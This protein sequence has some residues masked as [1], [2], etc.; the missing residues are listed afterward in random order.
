MARWRTVVVLA[1]PALLLAAF[2]LAIPSV[3]TALP[4]MTQRTVY[5]NPVIRWDFA[6]PHVMKASDGFYYAYSTEHLT[7]ER[8]AYIQV[9]RSKDL[10][11]WELLPDA[12]PEKPEWADTTRDFWAPG[13]IEADGRYYMYFSGIHDERESMCLGVATSG[14]PG[15]PFVP[16]EDPLRCGDGFVNIDPM[17]FDDPQTGKSLL[18]WGSDGAPI[19]VQQLA[20]D[21]LG[22]APG[23]RAKDL[24]FTDIIQPYERLVEGAF[25]VYRDDYYYLFYSGDNCCLPAPSY[26]VMVARSPSATG[27]FEKRS[28]TTGVWGSNVILQQNDRW[29]GTGHNSVVR[30]EAGRDWIFYHAIDPDDRYNPGTE[31]S[32]RPMLMDPIVYRSGWP[33]I[34]ESSPSTTKR[35]GPLVR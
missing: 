23:S 33:E 3:R 17:P 14:S 32:K 25:V 29:E 24:V 6:D 19:R 35:Q 8:L 12:M 1:A 31:A 10:V 11:D 18:Y 22:F 2:L 34:E 5:T 21:R 26:A 16:E 4:G 13:V 15:G 7:Y 9:A 30:D 27:P 28:E 20:R